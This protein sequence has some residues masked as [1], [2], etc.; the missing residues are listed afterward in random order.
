VCRLARQQNKTDNLTQSCIAVQQIY[1]YIVGEN[2]VY[3]KVSSND[4][5]EACKKTHADKMVIVE[6]DFLKQQR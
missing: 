4:L 3:F 6:E 1:Q 5:F 2:S